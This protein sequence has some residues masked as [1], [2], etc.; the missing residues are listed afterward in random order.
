MI[1]VATVL[2]HSFESY[3]ID[4]YGYE[5]DYEYEFNK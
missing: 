2:K 5:Y 3:C 4:G 1:R